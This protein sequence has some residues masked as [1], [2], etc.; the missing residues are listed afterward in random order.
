VPSVARQVNG[1]FTE[2]GSWRIR[3]RH[4]RLML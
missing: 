1:T 3:D 4:L 2:R